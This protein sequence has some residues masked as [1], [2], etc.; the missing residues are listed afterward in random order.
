MSVG[1]IMGERRHCSASG[2][3]LHASTAALPRLASCASC[4][5]GP[6]W[7]LPRPAGS[8][9]SSSLDRCTADGMHVM[10]C[11]LG[12]QHAGTAAGEAAARHE[13]LSWRRKNCCGRPGLWQGMYTTSGCP[14]GLP[15][16]THCRGLAAAGVLK[17]MRLGAELACQDA[18]RVLLCHDRIG[19]QAIVQTCLLLAWCTG[20]AN[21]CGRPECVQRCAV[22]MR[23]SCHPTR[24]LVVLSQI[25]LANVGYLVLD[26]AD[27]MLDMGFEPQ[28]RVLG[29]GSV[30]VLLQH[31]R[32]K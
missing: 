8:T 30:R 22:T 28:A 11:T 27:R 31:H 16:C 24:C 10:C 1:C 19:S 32:T 7:W 20:A 26:E 29:W 6:I 18:L 25:S 12:W 23:V 13:A 17:C 9:T 21:C 14:A 2:Y 3:G 4:S 15:A 5:M